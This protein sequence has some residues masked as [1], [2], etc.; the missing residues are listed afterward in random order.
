M[1]VK[2]QICPLP[3]IYNSV[4]EGLHPAFRCE[5]RQSNPATTTSI[6]PVS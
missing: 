2:C 4:N 1:G 3:K 6:D 5:V